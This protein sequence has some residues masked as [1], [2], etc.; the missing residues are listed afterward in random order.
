MEYIDTKIQDGYLHRRGIRG[1]FITAYLQRLPVEN[2]KRQNDIIAILGIKL[3]L[4]FYG[5]VL[6]M[7][8]RYALGLEKC[9]LP[10]AIAIYNKETIHRI[11]N[12]QPGTISL[13]IGWKRSQNYSKNATEKTKE[14]YAHYTEISGNIKARMI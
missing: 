1:R 12:I 11:R 4:L 7:N 6:L 5:E 8:I 13:F 3:F 14:G 9:L 10:T 2:Q